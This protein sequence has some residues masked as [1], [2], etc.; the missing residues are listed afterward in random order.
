MYLVLSP[1]TSSPVSLLATNKHS[2]FS[3][4]VRILPPNI[5][6]SA[7]KESAGSWVIN[8]WLKVHFLMLNLDK[9]RHIKVITKSSTITDMNIDC[10]IKPVT[11][12][13][14]TKFLTT[15]TNI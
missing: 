13:T 6:T 9:T 11:N 14:H 2:A 1:F 4:K 12:I 15:V 10:D 7:Y 8:N 5:L 3:Y